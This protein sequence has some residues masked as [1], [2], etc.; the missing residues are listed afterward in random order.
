[1][2]RDRFLVRFE[3]IAS[4]EAAEA[5][6]GTLYVPSTDIRPLESGEFW[7]H[8]VVGSTVVDTD[9]NEVGVVTDLIPGPAQD[10]LEVRGPTGSHLVPLVG[11]IVTEVRPD[12]RVIVIDPP[13]GLLD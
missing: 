2:H 8:D 6:R 3:G 10:L 9:G 13:A 5:I 11:D 1:M 4:R 12:R 7:E